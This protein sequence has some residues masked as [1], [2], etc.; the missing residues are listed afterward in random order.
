MDFS[1]TAEEESFREEM[2]RFLK[3]NPPDNF[4]LQS[5]SAGYGF[6]GYSRDFARAVGRAGLVSR[7]WPPEHGGKGD[8]LAKLLIRMEEFAYAEAPV[9]ALMVAESVSR[10]IINYGSDF[11][12]RE[13]LPKIAAG[14][15][16]FWLAFSE[17]DAGSDLLSVQ[18]RAEKSGD[19]YII[20]GQKAWSANAHAADYG[21]LLARTDPRVPRHKGL[22]MFILDKNLPGVSVRPLV[23]LEGTHYHTEVFLDDVRVHRDYL[24]GQENQGFR[25][26]MG[27]LEHD[28]FWARFVKAPFCKRALEE[29]IEYVKDQGLAGDPHIRRRLAEIAT[30]IEACRLLFYRTAWML[31][32]GMTPGYEGVMG[33]TFADELGQRL[34]T[35]GLQ[36]VG[37]YPRP[38]EDP[39]WEPLR[40]KLVHNYQFSLGHTLA[41]GPSE[42]MRTT[43]AIRGL[44]LPQD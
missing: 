39:R 26:M 34:F 15:A 28:R 1:F 20:N 25:Q 16:A 6:G 3:E 8:S 37:V 21:Y 29:I 11:L 18:T 32:Q 27:G 7:F 31:Q 38:G 33:K 36:I 35:L 17:P 19:C 24:V 40:K 44:G 4:S 5:V 13:F 42:I 41:G 2:R 10:L 30:D 9:A 12:K 22:S 43:A 23:N 14:E